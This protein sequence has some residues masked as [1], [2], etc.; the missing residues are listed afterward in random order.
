MEEAVLGLFPT[1]AEVKDNHL[2]IGGCDSLALA[3]EFGTP[4]YVFDDETLRRSCREFQREFSSRYPET[5]VIYACKALLLR[6]LVRLLVEEGLGLDV[7]SGGELAVA[8]AAGFPLDRVYFHGNNKSPQELSLALGAGVGRV[9]VDNFYELGLLEAEAKKGGRHQEVMLRLCPGVDPHTHAHTTT[10]AV[11]SKFG[12]PL[13]QGEKAITQAMA[14]PHLRLLGLHFHLGSPIFEVEPYQEAI[15]LV[16]GFAADMAEKFGF[17]LQ[18]FSPGGGFAIAYTRERLAPPAAYYAEGIARALL[19]G[20][21]RHGLPR[22]RL[23]LEPGR[24]LVGRAGAALYRAGSRKDIPGVRTYVSL[25]GGMGDNIRP[26]LYGARYEALVANRAGEQ[27]AERVTLAGR[28]CESG[29]VLIKDI[30]LPRVFPGDIV[31]IPAMGAYSIPMASNYNAAPRPAIVLVK[32]GRAELWR[33][34]ESYQDL[35]ALDV[36]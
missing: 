11:D 25:D 19:E 34:R 18:E 14:S 3:Q 16:L 8:R 1:T 26:A 12:F 10:G 15:R 21:E 28:F 36:D 35:M 20:L 2:F 4:L 31:A 27:P 32:K 17:H 23:I 24:A 13:E 7:V 9:V 22:P 5:R 29:D 33:R 6:P 30:F